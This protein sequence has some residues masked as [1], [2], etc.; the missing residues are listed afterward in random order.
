M[1]LDRILDDILLA[2]CVIAVAVF[3]WKISG[4]INYSAGYD[5]ALASIKPDTEYVEKEIYID[6]PVPAIEYK[7]TGRV[8]EIL[9]H[10]T[11]YVYLP[12]EVRQFAD[13]N[14]EIYELQV[15]GIDPTLDWIKVK[16]KTAYINVPVPEYKYP[17]IAISPSISAFVAPGHFSFGGG[18][19]FDYWKDRWQFSVEGG[20]GIH[21][22]FKT[23]TPGC[24]GQVNCKYNLIRK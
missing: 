15:S 18:L 9:I 2:V 14:K 11:T 16:Q 1:K 4:N 21:S 12:R 7:D 22:D 13:P 19:E 10:D 20:Y 5:D 3:S 23:I 24:Y 6:K 8:V 17:T